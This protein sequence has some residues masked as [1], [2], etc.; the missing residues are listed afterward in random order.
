[1][2]SDDEV[3]WKYS[4]EFVSLN[5][6]L[7]KGILGPVANQ[8]GTIV[9]ETKY[10][11]KDSSKL[12][13]RMI[14]VFGAVGVKAIIPDPED[15][16]MRN[17]I[18][19]ICKKLREKK[20][21]EDKADDDLDEG[22]ESEDEDMDTGVGM[23]NKTPLVMKEGFV[24]FLNP[25]D[26][27]KSFINEPA[28]TKEDPFKVSEDGKLIID[29]EDPKSKRKRPAPDDSDSEDDAFDDGDFEDGHE[30]KMKRKSPASIKSGKSKYSVKS[31][32]STTSS[33]VSVGNGKSSKSKM[34]SS[35][36]NKKGGDLT[37]QR[38]KMKAK[39]FKSSSSVKSS[40]SGKSR[41]SSAAST[42][43]LKF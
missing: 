29:V 6:Q 7:Y 41:K 42:F 18:K 43:R 12:L 27:A 9:S 33:K 4:L 1:M 24:D 30:K 26:I 23:S 20:G 28:P 2:N 8:L 21:K 25:S 22:E 19:N 37:V 31:F 17:R 36:E 11:K 15:S 5:L 38:K 14:K 39:R 3:A 34:K 13:A 35:K 10:P 40:K 32:K 16:K